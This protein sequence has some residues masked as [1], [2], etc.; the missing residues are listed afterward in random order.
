[1][2]SGTVVVIVIL[3]A[4]LLAVALAHRTR[5]EP[6]SVVYQRNDPLRAMA[7]ATD[8]TLRGLG[9]EPAWKRTA[10]GTSTALC[11]RCSGVL[12]L[13]CAGDGSG[14][15]AQAYPP[16]GSMSQLFECPGGVTVLAGSRA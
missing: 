12:T 13:T 3:L 15:L 5:P 2:S 16:V 6:G 10:P 9:H 8:D 7:E 4:G 14:A 11:E 1:M